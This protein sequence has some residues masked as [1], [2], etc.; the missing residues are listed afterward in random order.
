MFF[1]EGS[2]SKKER[3]TPFIPIRPLV[4]PI[5][6]I[7]LSFEKCNLSKQ[8]ILFTIPPWKLEI[9]HSRAFVAAI[10]GHNSFNWLTCIFPSRSFA[11]KVPLYVPS[12]FLREPFTDM[13]A[14]DSLNFIESRVKFSWFAIK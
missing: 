12:I 7:K 13:I 10:V 5:F 9:T 8:E 1:T 3:S 11:N 6:D 4:S 14:S 2:P